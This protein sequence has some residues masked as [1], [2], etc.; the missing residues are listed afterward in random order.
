MLSWPID[1]PV[2]RKLETHR[3]ADSRSGWATTKRTSWWS[4]PRRMTDCLEIH[5]TAPS[6]PSLNFKLT[7]SPS[8]SRSSSRSQ[9][10][11]MGGAVLALLLAVTGARA[12]TNLSVWAFPGPSGWWRWRWWRAVLGAPCRVARAVSCWPSTLRMPRCW[13]PTAA[14]CA[15]IR[16]SLSTHC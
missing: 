14:R 4:C 16:S 2:F 8:R 11:G 9:T 10:A 6:L 13:W 12:D 1:V 7:G 3:Q 5:L 15:G